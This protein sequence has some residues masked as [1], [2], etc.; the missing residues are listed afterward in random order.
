[1]PDELRELAADLG[2]VPPAMI[3]N[4]Q[5][6]IEVTARNIKDDWESNL[7][8]DSGR[9]LRYTG[10]SVDYDMNTGIGALAA[11][12]V[13]SNVSIEAEIGPNLKRP[14]GRPQGSMAGWF[15]SGNVDGIPATE[16]GDAAM[17]AN[18][19]DFYKGLELA[20]ADALRD[21]L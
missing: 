9:R 5:K 15:E 3:R 19:S 12:G 7:R 1:M 13:V 6:A 18:V 2:R 10:P 21:A 14:F 11:L 20:A 16:P 4:T 17:E 8:G